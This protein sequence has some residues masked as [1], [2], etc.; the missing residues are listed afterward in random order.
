MTALPMI[1]ARQCVRAL[2]KAGFFV[3]RRRGS[4]IVLRREEP[5]PTLTVI[6]PNHKEIDRGTLKSIIRQA[7]LTVEEFADLLK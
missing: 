7:K 5:P 1:S 6:V 4:H 3:D 2:E